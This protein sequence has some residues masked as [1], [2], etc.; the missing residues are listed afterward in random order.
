MRASC[1]TPHSCLTG[2]VKESGLDLPEDEETYLRSLSGVAT[3]WTLL[4]ELKNCVVGR[5]LFA[6]GTLPSLSPDAGG[7]TEGHVLFSFFL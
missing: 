7:G 3:L 4:L 1:V 6:D 2:P 5:P